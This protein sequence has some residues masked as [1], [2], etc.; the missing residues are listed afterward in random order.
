MASALAATAWLIVGAAAW[1]GIFVAGVTLAWL[2]SR[3]WPTRAG[4]ADRLDAALDARELFGT[5]VRVGETTVLGRIVHDAAD[6]A[7][8]GTTPRAV[9]PWR[10]GRFGWIARAIA[11]LAG[12]V[13]AWIG[14]ASAEKANKP[15]DT[16]RTPAP[17]VAADGLIGG[18]SPSQSA[19]PARS[20]E[21]SNPSARPS[22]GPSAAVARTAV[23][24]AASSGNPARPQTNDGAGSGRPTLEEPVV[25]PR[26][27]RPIASPATPVPSSEAASPATGGKAAA[28]TLETASAMQVA[29]RIDAER[30][31]AG[32][33]PAVVS[34]QPSQT[35]PHANATVPAAYREI[36]RRFF[37]GGAASEE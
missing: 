12:V 30:P 28:S 20:P 14:F 15:N 23:A 27:D 25:T 5:A 9:N 37:A 19:P 26:S 7:A 18:P 34:A 16:A 1:V 35:D 36:V 32:D 8:G 10:R 29:G 31:A 4:A 17:V 3:S 13:V 33:P 6:R 11:L 24:P 2:T 21:A 22:G